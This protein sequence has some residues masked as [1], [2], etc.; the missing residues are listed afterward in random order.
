MLI[1]NLFRKLIRMWRMKRDPIGYIRSLGVQIGEN[2]RLIGLEDTTFGSEPYLIK[3]GNHVTITSG[4]RF[5]THDGGVWIFRESEPNI[6]VVAP[7][8]VGDNVFIG[9][10]SI[11]LPGVEIGSN[12]VIGAGSVVTK[13]IPPNQVAAGVPTKC[14]KT[15]EEYRL[16]LEPKVRH[17]R[18]LADAEKRRVLLKHFDLR[19]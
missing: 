3:I 13:N 11:I 15:I 19:S 8:T 16:G 7:I 2:C 17:V 5:I 14:I 10:N 1:L 18:S 12:C 9:M 6:D 4:V